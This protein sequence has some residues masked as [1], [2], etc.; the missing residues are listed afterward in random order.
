MSKTDWMCG[1][2]CGVWLVTTISIPF[3]NG[4]TV[5]IE[6]A[7]LNAIVSAVAIIFSSTF[8]VAVPLMIRNLDARDARQDA[9]D[10]GFE[11]ARW[12]FAMVAAGRRHGIVPPQLDAGLRSQIQLSE[13]RLQSIE[14]TRLRST[15]AA[16]RVRHLQ[17]LGKALVDVM[18]HP[19]AIDPAAAQAITRSSEAIADGV[20]GLA[21]LVEKR[22]GMSHA[23]IVARLTAD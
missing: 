4:V 7:T 3:V 17:S 8:A 1:A 10:A 9:L 5:V 23:E 6:Q 11:L 15:T 2:L 19:G 12:A 22:P 16:R 20:L 18:P 21:K 14:L 13:Q